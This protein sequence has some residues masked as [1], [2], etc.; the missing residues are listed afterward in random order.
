MKDF[1]ISNLLKNKDLQENYFKSS[2]FEKKQIST[3]IYK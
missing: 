2:P 3:N 1:K